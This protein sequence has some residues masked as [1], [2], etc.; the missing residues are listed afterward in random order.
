MNSVR[1]AQRADN[2]MRFHRM[3]APIGA[4]KHGQPSDLV[5][6][7]RLLE[8]IGLWPENKDI[9]LGRRSSAFAD[10]LSPR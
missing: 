10:S 9:N 8:L 1:K 4:V 7:T 6:W 3:A 5:R 2:S